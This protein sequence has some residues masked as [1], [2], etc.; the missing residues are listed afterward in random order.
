M[1]TS[2][3][4]S[5]LPEFTD[6]LNRE[7][8]S[9][10]LIFRGQRCDWPLV[11][12]LAR[13]NLQPDETRIAIERKLLND[14]K[15][16]GLPLCEIP[17]TTDFEW[18]AVGQHYGLPTRLLDWT[19]SALS[20]LWFAISDPADGEASAIVHVMQTEP[21]D[22][23]TSRD[24][25]PFT[26]DRTKLFRPR[27]IAKRI[28]AQ[29]GLFTIHR[30]T[31]HGQFTPLQRESG[32][33]NWL[34]AIEIPASA[35]GAVRWQLDQCGVNRASLFGDLSALCQHLEWRYSLGLDEGT[36]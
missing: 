23:V 13:V 1:A 36:G 28:V 2:L 15:L 14:L 35:F 25:S 32:F 4:A 12:K 21:D 27:H 31:S 24:R 3:V 6:I 11:P 16:Q 26:L 8:D 5:S 10:G 29:G 22:F 30:T 34:W 18:I 33:S 17:P 7:F 20:A 9:E 19:T